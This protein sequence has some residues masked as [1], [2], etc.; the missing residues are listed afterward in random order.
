MKVH[1]SIIVAMDKNRVIGKNGDLPWRL[2]A[3]LKRVKEITMGKP[4]VMGRKNFESIG[5]VLSGRKNVVMT[6]RYNYCSEG[7]TVVH[8]KEE[9]L[10]EC[11]GFA[12]AFIFGGEQ[13]YD[14]FKNDVDTI[15]MTYIDHGFEEVGS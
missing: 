7:V 3:D 11:K 8:S 14:L 4:I 12:E 6:N 15:Y 1:L 2:P 10:D 13:V 9:A 5:K